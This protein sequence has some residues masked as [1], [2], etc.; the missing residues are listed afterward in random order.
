MLLSITPT[1]LSVSVLF[2][3]LRLLHKLQYFPF[4]VSMTVSSLMPFLMLFKFLTPFFI[5][6]LLLHT[7]MYTYISRYNIFGLF[8][9]TSMYVFR[10]DHLELDNNLVSHIVLCGELRSHGLFPVKF[11]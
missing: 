11:S 8:S 1:F 2:L 10:D 5:S 7:C 3:T 4:P 6:H 9:V